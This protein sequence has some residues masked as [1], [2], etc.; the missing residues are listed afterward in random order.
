MIEYVYENNIDDRVL[1]RADRVLSGG[2]LVAFPTD[3]SWAIGGSVDSREAI[4]KLKKLKGGVRNYTISMICQDISQMSDVA[5]ID[6]PH[7]KLIK[8]LTPGAYVFVLPARN[9][10]EKIINMKRMEIGLRM[11]DSPIPKAL[12]QKHGAPIFSI[13]ACRDMN[14]KDWWDY[15]FA[16]ENLFESGWEL[17]DIEGVEMVIDTGEAQPKHLTTVIRLTED[18][19]EIIREGS[20]PLP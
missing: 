12:V 10:V 16:E 1:A 4:E 9:R 8:R 17:E 6:T 7:F 20:G 11:A 2:G 13:T 15:E 14:N 3:S 19:P 5:K 18:E